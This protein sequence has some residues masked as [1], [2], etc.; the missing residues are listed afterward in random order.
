M[1]TVLIVGLGGIGSWF[2][3]NVMHYKKVGQFRDTTF[4]GADPDII[5]EKNTKYQNFKPESIL[6]FKADA[7]EAFYGITSYDYAIEKPDQLQGY[8]C[9]VSAVD[10]T[11]FRRM[12]FNTLIQENNS[13]YWI[14]LRSEGQSIAFFTKS[15][16][17]TLEKM[18]KTLPEQDLEGGSCQLEY[19]LEQDI[20]QGG[21]RI[22]AEIGAQLLL[23]WSRKEQNP[24]Q[25]IQRF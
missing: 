18:L 1:S 6:D 25:F 5:E 19:E 10:S 16:E 14:D 9:I 7:M 3:H 22:I 17:N 4:F 2:L 23:N 13:T 11:T 21:N 24:A 15:K 20:I 12:M 8:D